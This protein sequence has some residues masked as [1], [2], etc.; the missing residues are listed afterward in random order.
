M[1]NNDLLS[2]V[3]AVYIIVVNLIGAIINIAD[4]SRAKKQKQRI[5]ENTLWLIALLGGSAGSYIT[6]KA[7]RHKTKHKSFMIGFPL[8]IILQALLIII[9]ILNR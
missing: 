3:I 9:Y 2:A 8:I 4:K 1:L 5:R 6:M 7:I